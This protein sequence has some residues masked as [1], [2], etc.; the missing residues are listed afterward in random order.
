MTNRC[1]DMTIDRINEAID[2]MSIHFENLSNALKN[3][4]EK[5][6]FIEDGVKETSDVVSKISANASK[7]KILAL[8][9]IS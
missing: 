8:S 1:T 4:Q 9:N 6:G 3:M 5:T 7:S 2:M